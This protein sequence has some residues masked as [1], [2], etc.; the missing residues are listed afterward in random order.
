MK[1]QVYNQEGKKLEELE[2]SKAVFDVKMNS[3]LVHQ[4]VVSQISNRRQ[5]VAKVKDRSEKRGGGIKPW[6]Q[7]GTGRARHGSIRS[8]LWKGGGVTFGPRTEK[9]FKKKVPIKMRRKALFMVLTAKVKNKMFLVLD[10]LKIDK[11]STKATNEMLKKLFL[12]KGSGLMLLDKNDKNVIKSINNIPKVDTMP[13]KD[14]NALDLLQYKYII[15]SKEG[16]KII[17]K[18]FIK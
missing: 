12:T 9:N 15:V 6:R 2:L 11:I 7:K 14:I 18:T 8:P 3:D 1:T 10:Q 17:E 16:L 13:A 5:K 4:V